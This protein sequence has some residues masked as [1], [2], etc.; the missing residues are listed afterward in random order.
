MNIHP[1]AIVS[2]DVNI[3]EGATIGAYS[4]IGRQVRIGSNTAIAS[5]V[6][7]E[8]GTEIGENCQ[9][10][11][12]SCI[13]GVPQ[14][15]KFKGEITR[16][17]IGNFNNIREFVTIN[18]ATV[19][20]IGVTM[21]G[22]HNL[23]MAY[24]HVAHNCHLANNIVLANGTNLAGHVIIEDYAVVGGLTG[25]HQFT[26]IGAHSMI[27]GA[28][29]VNKDVPPYVTASG[30]HARLYGLNLIGMKR[31]GFS[32]E[33]LQALKDSYRIIFR[34]S[35]LLSQAIAQVRNDVPDFVEVRHFLDFIQKS[36]RGVCR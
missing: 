9:I 21:I 6:V 34:S 12:F 22:D 24:C 31:R 14:D 26:H 29:A 10:S 1:T 7:I 8:A 27:G 25:V 16:V 5:H 20:D 19:D 4:V 17:V 18:R 32:A 13:G 15:L 35:M 3:G 33:V 2:P 30:N 11:Q 36:K 28:S 23:I